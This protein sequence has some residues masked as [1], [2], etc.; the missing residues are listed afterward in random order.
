[1]R[2]GA[3]YSG[4]GGLVGALADHDLRR[5]VDVNLRGGSGRKGDD[6]AAY[7]ITR[8]EGTERWARIAARKRRLPFAIDAFCAHIDPATLRPGDVVMGTLPVHVIAQVIARGAEFWAL[9]IDVPPDLRGVEMS[10]T[11]LA[12]CNARLTRYQVQAGESTALPPSRAARPMPSRSLGVMLVSNALTPNYIGFHANPT[13]ALLLLYTKPMRARHNALRKMLAETGMKQTRA[14][15]IDDADFAAMQDAMRTALTERA[16]EYAVMRLNLTGGTKPMALALQRASDE[17]AR[18][19]VDLHADYVDAQHGRI[20]DLRSGAEQAIPAVLD[21]RAAVRAS[22]RAPA[23]CLS[24]A[25]VFRDFMRREALATELLASEHT[26]ELHMLAG[27]MADLLDQRRNRKFDCIEND[28]ANAQR[29]QFTLSGQGEQRLRWLLH[30][31]RLAIALRAHGVLHA[32][33]VDGRVRLRLGTLADIAYLQGTW[34]EALVAA[35]I[36]EAAA[37]DW[38]AGVQVGSERGRNNELD[39]LLCCGNQ[40]LLIEVKAGNLKRGATDGKAADALYKLESIGH[41]LA[42]EFG[43]NWLVSRDKLDDI[44]MERARQQRITVLALRDVGLSGLRDHLDDWI[45]SARAKTGPLRVEPRALGPSLDAQ[46][47]QKHAEGEWPKRQSGP[48][49]ARGGTPGQPRVRS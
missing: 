15:E 34:L 29:G 22:G 44:D 43:R 10:A 28:P 33:R 6:L 8:H 40:T 24:A 25:P 26:G 7:F 2:Q 12:A 4:H 48:P 30:D 49:Q 32:E 41:T 46:R 11:Q 27:Q 1:M 39:A 35:I 18:A 14:V 36:A 3:P 23:G 31:G 20:L 16:D 17:L 38:A 13:D 42:K 45:K 5:P 19:G 9:D 37:D 21:V 47:L